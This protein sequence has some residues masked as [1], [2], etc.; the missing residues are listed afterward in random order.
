MSTFLR[1]LA[2][3]VS[4]ARMQ[5]NRLFKLVVALAAF[6]LLG[7]ATADT[8]IPIVNGN[9]LAGGGGYLEG[10]YLTYG[11]RFDPSE[12]GVGDGTGYSWGDLLTNNPVDHA[13]GIFGF[14][15][16]SCYG[17]CT[18]GLYN[19]IQQQPESVTSSS[20]ASIAA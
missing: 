7:L 6:C 4:A 1:T 10:W 5:L 18:F 9:G 17:K 11:G 14:F 20:L 12:G 3:H 19:A 15:Q 2:S 8:N 13:F 16:T